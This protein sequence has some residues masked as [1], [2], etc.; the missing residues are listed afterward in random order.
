[1][2]KTGSKFKLA[3]IQAELVDDKFKNIE[4]TKEMIDHAATSGAQVVVLG[5][6]FICD[7][8][9]EAFKANAE[10]IDDF[11]TNEEAYSM[12]M[13]SQAAKDNQI[14]IIGGSIPEKFE[15]NIYNTCACFD[16]EGKLKRK[17]RK[18]HLFD[19]EIPGKVKF[20]ESEAFTPGD[21]FAVFK[22]EFCTFGIGVCYDIRFPDYAQVL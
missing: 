5:E 7:Y 6:I 17:H 8:S 1:M 9:I 22:T 21:D 4:K 10:S 20:Y 16:K 11:E 12:R 14:Y 3:I 13:L 18:M 19:L 15:D 2:E